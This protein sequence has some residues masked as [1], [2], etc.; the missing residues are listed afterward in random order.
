MFRLPAGIS[1][2][3]SNS[4]VTLTLGYGFSVHHVRVPKPVGIASRALLSALIHVHG[5]AAT[6]DV[7]P[8]YQVLAPVDG[9]G[10]VD[11]TRLD[12]RI[13]RMWNDP[14][15]GSVKGLAVDAFASPSELEVDR[16]ADT[17]LMPA[18]T[19]K[20]LTAVAALKTFGPEAR[21]A[22]T[23]TRDGRRLVLVGAVILN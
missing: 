3:T 13:D 22:T 10:P 14:A 7:P 18:S 11:R 15:L 23:V 20:M 1:I 16:G 2:V 5:A 12:A 8:D 17:A 6:V 21:F 19:T 9:I 4:T